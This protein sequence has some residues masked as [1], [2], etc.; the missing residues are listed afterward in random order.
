MVIIQELSEQ[1]E[2]ELEDACNYIDKALHTVDKDKA[3]ADL[4]AQLSAEEMGHVDKLHNRVVAV[5]DQY[6]KEHGPS[7]AE[8]Q[9]RYG[10]LHNRHISKATRIKVKQ[11][12]YKEGT[13]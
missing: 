2:E 8:M 12:L 3:T 7:P 1:I 11:A 4:Y 5:I 10:Y 13:K 9:W 6:R